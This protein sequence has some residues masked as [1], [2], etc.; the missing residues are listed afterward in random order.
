MAENIL[1]ALLVEVVLSV[2]SVDDVLDVPVEEAVLLVDEVSDVPEVLDVPSDGG[3]P[4]G[5]PIF[6]MAASNSASL[7]T[8]SLLVSM[9]E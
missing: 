8:P 2:L 4:G 9:D 6:A 7:T 5:G 1:S 3:G